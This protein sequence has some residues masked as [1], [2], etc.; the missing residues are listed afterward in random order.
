[1]SDFERFLNYFYD[2]LVRLSLENQ[3]Q[4]IKNNG[5]DKMIRSILTSGIVTI[6][7][8]LAEAILLILL[9]LNLNNLLLIFLS[10]AIHTL[11]EPEAH[12]HYFP[13]LWTRNLYIDRNETSGELYIR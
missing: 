1:M 8:S 13:S 11:L 6:K 4:L 2:L 5:Q 7:A 12:F 9:V 3:Q 10:A